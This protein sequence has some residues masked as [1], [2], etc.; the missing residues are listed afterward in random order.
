M[1]E[2]DEAWRARL[3]RTSIADLAAGVARDASP[4]AIER[5]GTWLQEVMP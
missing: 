1:V 4:K 3:A 5:F 2:A